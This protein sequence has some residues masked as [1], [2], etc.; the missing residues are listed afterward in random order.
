MVYF[1]GGHEQSSFVV[2]GAITHTEFDPTKSTT[3]SSDAN[4]AVS[5]DISDNRYV[6]DTPLSV[7]NDGCSCSVGGAG[8][9]SGPGRVFP[10]SA[11][12]GQSATLGPLGLQGGV[13][14]LPHPSFRFAQPVTDLTVDMRDITIPGNEQKVWHE[15]FRLAQPDGSLGGKY[16]PSS[17]PAIDRT[18]SYHFHKLCSA[19]NS[20][21]VYKLKIRAGGQAPIDQT[22]VLK[23]YIV[24]P[25]LLVDP[26]NAAEG[27]AGATG[28][29]V[30][31]GGVVSIK[32]TGPRFS[33]TS[34]PASDT[35]SAVK[36][37]SFAV[38]E[39]E[40]L[41][42][43]GG[44]VLM[45]PDQRHFPSI[46]TTSFAQ[47]SVLCGGQPAPVLKNPMGCHNPPTVTIQTP[48]NFF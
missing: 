29:K 1:F 46:T 8:L 10:G 15:S 12:G 28:G 43:N 13:P 32:A 31:S 16:L 2:A 9:V 14:G 6:C 3:S 7:T 45:R 19:M 35:A 34:A 38:R 36:A 21:R 33:E 17:Q 11:L 4:Y 30:E 44:T 39:D 25:D 24:K 26:V 23:T 18:D 5:S 20:W 40:F 41:V 27:G 22:M 42:K 37:S 48:S 47:S